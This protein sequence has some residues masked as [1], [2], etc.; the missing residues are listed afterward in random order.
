MGAEAI[1][2]RLESFDAWRLRLRLSGSVQT[3][4]EEDPAP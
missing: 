1:K 2:K 3:G 4:V